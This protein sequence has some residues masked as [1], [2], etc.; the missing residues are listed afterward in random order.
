MNW[1]FFW[2]IIIGILTLE[3]WWWGCALNRHSTW[4]RTLVRDYD[5]GCFLQNWPRVF[6]AS[7]MSTALSLCSALWWFVG[8]WT[9]PETDVHTAQWLVVGLQLSHIHFFAILARCTCLEQS[10]WPWLSRKIS[11]MMG[12]AHGLCAKDDH[13]SKNKNGSVFHDELI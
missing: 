7:V 4:M 13:K 2:H 5:D 1:S 10:Y 8:W 3:V 6:M 12:K 9:W 11:K